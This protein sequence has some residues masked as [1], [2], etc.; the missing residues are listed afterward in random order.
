VYSYVE[1][2]ANNHRARCRLSPTNLL[3]VYNPQNSQFDDIYLIEKIS[4]KEG[5]TP[6]APDENWAFGYQAELKDFIDC[7]TSGNTPQSD[8]VLAIDTTMALYAAYLSAE[9]NGVEQPIQLL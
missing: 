3:D 8:L 7:A 4:S 1:I 9:S 6:A 5:W 2:F